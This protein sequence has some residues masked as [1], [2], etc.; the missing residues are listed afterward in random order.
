[1]QTLTYEQTLA[2]AIRIDVPLTAGRLLCAFGRHKRH[3]LGFY[4]LRR[5]CRA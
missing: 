1:M 4:C 5:G 3:Y 2:R